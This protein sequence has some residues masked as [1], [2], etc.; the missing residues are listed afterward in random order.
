[1]KRVA[2]LSFDWDYKIVSDYYL[3]LQDHLKD[4]EGVQA[5]IFNAFGRY[6]VSHQPQ[7]STFE[8]FSLFDPEDYDG[9]IIQGNRSWPPEVRQELVD[10]VTALGKPVV[11]IN[12][13]LQGAHS[14]GTNNYQ[15]EYELVYRVLRDRGCKK[16]AFVN[17]LKTSVEAQDRARAYRDACSRLG[18][19]DARF[20]QANWQLEAGM[21]T[22][23]KM[24]RKPND[25]PDIV[26]CCNDDL[27]VGVQ[28]TLQDAGIRVPADI[29][30]TG[31]DNRVIS[32]RTSPRIT[33]VDRD[34]RTIAATA[35]DML[36]QLM[37]GKDVPSPA[38]S[39]AKY[40]FAESCGYPAKANTEQ[41]N[42]RN[43]SD[44]ELERFF[45]VLGDFQSVVLGSESLYTILENCEMFARKIECP[46]VYLTL[47]DTYLH[48]GNP[49]GA[50]T[51]GP[52]CHLMARK[53]RTA[54]MRCN[55]DHV[56]ES[57]PTERIL[58]PEDSGDAAVYMVSPL[59]YNDACIGTV[60]TEG[61]PKC[62]RYGFNAFFLTVLS[63]AIVAARK[64]ELLQSAME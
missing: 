28:E 42:A 16:P 41:V 9:V 51:Y 18:I 60:V 21:V 2:F 17:G 14:V 43:A 32:Q 25:L 62:I 12:Y 7:E 36:L 45:E 13:D 5:V 8:I 30:I 50:N 52:V 24:L 40:I 33:T 1:M 59:R 39:P 29:M 4:C 55:D 53:G 48:Q 61:V 35:L 19:A 58:P 34:Y 15:E 64:T 46:N 56:Y 54:I 49:G 37:A 31:F 10:K 22:A 6:Y 3:G 38:Y 27:A 57:Y 47:D 11:S 23:K 26:F 63:S 44:T 20:Y